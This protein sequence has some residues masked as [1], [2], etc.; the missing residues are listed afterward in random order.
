MVAKN[1]E[2]CI[3]WL[4]VH[5]GSKYT[6]DPDDPGGPTKYGITLIDY[7]LYVNKRGR[8]RDVARL[9]WP[10][11]KQI[12]KKKYWDRCR[13]DELPSGVDYCVFDY[14]VNS[15]TGRPRK[16]LRKLVGQSTRKVTI[17][18]AVLTAIGKRNSIDIINHMCTER[19]AFLR[20]LRIWWKY[21]RGWS[22]RVRDVRRRSIEFASST[23]FL[24]DPDPRSLSNVGGK[25]A[26][27]PSKATKPTILGTTA[28]AA[29]S[30]SWLDPQWIIAFILGAI[31][32]SVCI[33]Y[34]INYVRR[35]RQEAPMPIMPLPE[36]TTP[37]LEDI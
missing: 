32:L 29:S 1:F 16:V 35:K 17:T 6:N 33:H 9:T 15:G 36:I 7:R 31:I 25:G 37:T 22:R 8:A 3:V 24:A 11:A 4:K 27:S 10:V 23:Q 28:I 2:K 20:G 19:M 12:Y 34:I 30:A 26:I 14:G 18:D 5:E 13:C 21:G